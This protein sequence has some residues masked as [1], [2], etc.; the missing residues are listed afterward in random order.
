M[1]LQSLFVFRFDAVKTIKWF[2]V[3]LCCF[4]SNSKYSFFLF[5]AN[6]RRAHLLFACVASIIVGKH[7][8]F[9][10]SYQDSFRRVNLVDPGLHMS[11]I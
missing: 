10:M 3:S 8:Q 9:M 2:V 11:A 1:P 7:K 6:L 4:F 5:M